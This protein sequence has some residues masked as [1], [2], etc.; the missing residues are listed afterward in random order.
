MH[1]GRAN[2]H[3]DGLALVGDHGGM[4]ALVAVGFG[5]GDVIL[6][7][8]RNWRPDRMHN[9]QRVVTDA[10][11][12]L[13]FGLQAH[14]VMLF[15]LHVQRVVRVGAETQLDFRHG[16]GF[17]DHADRQQVKNL[18]D[19][20]GVTLHLGVDRVQVFAAPGNLKS[21]QPAFQFAVI[22]EVLAQERDGCTD[23]L[24][25]FNLFGS[26]LRLEFLEFL[27]VKVLE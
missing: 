10:F 22:L 3:L 6:E 26:D 16:S 14:A 4:Q 23:V 8:A 12:A 17:Q 7:T 18:F 20:A 9:P 19:V 5:H 27:G 15:L 2:L 24:V 13:Q 11:F 1:A 25:A 21:N